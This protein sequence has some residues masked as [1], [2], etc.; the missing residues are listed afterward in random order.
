ML[1]L[2]L[3]MRFCVCECPPINAAREI[4]VSSDTDSNELSDI[5]LRDSSDICGQ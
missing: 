4:D 5:G 3:I 1:N 2:V